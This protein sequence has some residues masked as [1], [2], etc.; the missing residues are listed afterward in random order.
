MYVTY[1]R[2]PKIIIYLTIQQNVTNNNLHISPPYHTFFPIDHA[3]RIQQQDDS[4]Y[5]ASQLD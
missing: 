4:G 1:S 3:N 5:P 2:N